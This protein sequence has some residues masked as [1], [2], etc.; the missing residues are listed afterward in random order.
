VV[1]CKPWQVVPSFYSSTSTYKSTDLFLTSSSGPSRLWSFPTPSWRVPKSTAKGCWWKFWI[2]SWAKASFLPI[3]PSGKS[4]TGNCPFVPQAM[5]ES[6]DYH[7][8]RTR[9]NW[10]SPMI[11]NP[12]QPRGRSLTWKN[13]FAASHSTLLAKPSSIRPSNAF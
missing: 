12:N 9:R 8:C 7:L 13:V 11:Y 3:Q 6:D 4:V 10:F 1:T 5:V 2:P